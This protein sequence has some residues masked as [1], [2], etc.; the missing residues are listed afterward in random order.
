M[1]VLPVNLRI[2]PVIGVEAGYLLLL[3]VVED[4]VGA[5]ASGG[6]VEDV[7]EQG[8]VHLERRN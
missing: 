5:G 8:L 2:S 6:V 3:S 4:G 1:V 7:R